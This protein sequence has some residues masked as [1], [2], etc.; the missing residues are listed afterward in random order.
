MKEMKTLLFQFQPV[1]QLAQFLLKL[2]N[3]RIIVYNYKDLK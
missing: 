3:N 2:Y 1:T